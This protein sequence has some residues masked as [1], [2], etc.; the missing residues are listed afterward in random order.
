MLINPKTNEPAV[1]A[2]LIGTL[3][4][5][6]LVMIQK[7]YLIPKEAVDKNGYLVSLSLSLSLSHAFMPS[8]GLIR[9]LLS[10][11]L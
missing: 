8:V 4:F 7:R 2:D 10:P 3:A 9:S 1:I 6:V 5:P 11:L